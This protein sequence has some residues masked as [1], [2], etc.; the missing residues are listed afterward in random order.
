MAAPLLGLCSEKGGDTTENDTTTQGVQSNRG[1]ASEG[2]GSNDTTTETSSDNQPQ[3]KADEEGPP[4]LTQDTVPE[5]NE[6][7]ASIK[8]ATPVALRT[9]TRVTGQQAT[10][11]RIDNSKEKSGQDTIDKELIRQL[12]RQFKKQ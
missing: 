2:I 1:E 12:T 7:Q 10:S 4:E 8:E 3:I 5:G 9:R 11:K 6:Q